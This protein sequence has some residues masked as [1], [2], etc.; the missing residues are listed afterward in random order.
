M[1]K[2]HEN[3][4]GSSN[5]KYRNKLPDDIGSFKD[6]QIDE[7]ATNTHKKFIE[8]LKIGQ[9][10][11]SRAYLKG[12]YETF[13]TEGQFWPSTIQLADM[14]TAYFPGSLLTTNI[15]EMSYKFE[16][17]FEGKLLATLDQVKIT[18][19]TGELTQEWEGIYEGDVFTIGEYYLMHFAS[20]G[21]KI[22]KPTRPV[23]FGVA[24]VNPIVL[25]LYTEEKE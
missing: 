16:L 2:P 15:D 24:L 7:F 17:S 5:N 10:P 18:F 23:E 12:F 21:Y 8:D 20:L 9:I 14:L 6:D 11:T 4:T 3:T 22:Y 13:G 1:E 25:V 19:T